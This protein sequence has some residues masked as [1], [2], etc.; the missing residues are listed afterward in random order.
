MYPLAMHRTHRRRRLTWWLVL[1]AVVV[2]VAMWGIW[3]LGRHSYE[4][5]S[6]GGTYDAIIQSAAVRHGVDSRLIKAVI[7]QESRFRS[8]AR[9]SKGEIG[10]MQIMPGSRHALQDWADWNRVSLPNE[11]ILSNP[12]LNIEVGTWY[13]SRALRRWN[14]Y[15][16][17]VEL[18]LCEYNAGYS[19][20]RTWCPPS[21][22]GQVIDRISYDGTRAYVVAIMGKYK[23]YKD[24]STE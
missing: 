9:G 10:L 11:G 1:F 24:T 22:D 13:L 7:W 16:G 4:Y 19:K 2:V 18:A 3:K 15:E 5:F 8:D 12:V 23:E 21:Y 14:R 17:G 20:A 6:S